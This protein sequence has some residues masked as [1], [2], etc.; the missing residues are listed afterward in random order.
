MT[1][2]RYIARSLGG[3][4]SG[5]QVIAPGP[6][7]SPHDRS[8]AVRPTPD[9][10]DGFQVYSHAGDDWQQCR[11]YVRQRLGLPAWQPGDERHGQRTIPQQQIDKWD[12][13]VIDRESEDRRSE[14]D[15]IRIERAAKL[16]NE[17]KSP[18]GTAAQDYLRSRA[19]DLTDDIAGSVLRFHPRCP[20]RDENTGRT[21]F[22]PCLLAAFR[23]IDD[24]TVTAV[25]RIRVDRPKRWPKTDRRMLGVVH[26]AAV[27]LGAA[28]DKLTIGEG[29]ETCLAAC[30]L[31]LGPAWALGSV[32]AISFFP[33]LDDIRELTILA[34]AGE[35]SSRAIKIC[36]RRWRR[37]GRRVLI[38]RSEVGSDHNDIL[39]R[40]T[41]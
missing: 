41:S 37:G 35:A 6:G 25:H 1:D 13:D 36:G 17:A 26:R 31:E 2:L 23:S 3:E 10:P 11:D 19:L 15:L 22:I 18:L 8:L 5:R 24:D 9:A 38:S 7:H 32:G 20:W 28:G 40:R 39:M 27:K 30:Q 14:D 4:V 12:F 33:L 21:E 34:E 16:W 29:V